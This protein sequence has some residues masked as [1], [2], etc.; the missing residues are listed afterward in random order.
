MET[1]AI[2]AALAAISVAVALPSW[3]GTW[4]D[5]ASGNLTDDAC[6]DGGTAPT[7]GSLVFANTSGNVSYVTNNVSG[8]S[9]SGDC[10]INSGA[11]EFSGAFP[12]NSNG[13]LFGSTAN[14]TVTVVNYSDWS[15]SWYMDLCHESGTTVVMTNRAGTITAYGSG[16][17]SGS[18]SIGGKN[19]TTTGAN[20]TLV[21]EGGTMIARTKRT[22]RRTTGRTTKRTTRSSED[23]LV[24]PISPDTRQN[25]ERNTRRK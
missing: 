21:F 6:W 11:W 12:K 25:R 14:K 18:I 23:G 2:R 16:G 24:K 20:A 8:T 7:S 5:G 13:V 1:K 9:W 22:T 17:A 4:L 10:W 3:A 19:S 15:P